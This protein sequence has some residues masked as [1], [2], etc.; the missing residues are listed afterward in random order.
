MCNTYYRKTISL[1][2]NFQL[3]L[4]NKQFNIKLCKVFL[5]LF[6]HIFFKYYNMMLKYI[7]LKQIHD[8]LVHY[9]L[10]VHSDY[11]NHL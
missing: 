8:Y 2:K 5:K 11:D 9:L 1:Y 7:K 4:T 3:P 10:Y 6:L